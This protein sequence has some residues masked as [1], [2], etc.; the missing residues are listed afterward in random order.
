MKKSFVFAAVAAFG[1]MSMSTT[2]NAFNSSKCLACHAIDH[3]KVGPA[4]KDVVKAYGDEA[5]L[6]K[7]FESGFAVSDRKIAGTEAKWKSKAGLMTMQYKHLIKGH[8][9]E[10]AHALFET[11]KN[12]KFGEY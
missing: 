8:D 10:V 12:G 2:A 3:A 9:K 7:V 6:A 5:T 11:V 4:W 1:L